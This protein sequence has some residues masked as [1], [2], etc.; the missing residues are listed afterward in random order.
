MEM[1]ETLELGKFQGAEALATDLAIT[2]TIQA[3]EMLSASQT[4]V[5][6]TFFDF[7]RRSQYLP[8]LEL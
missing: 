7:H 2:L 4:P 8:L 5:C 6:P 1:N 3:P